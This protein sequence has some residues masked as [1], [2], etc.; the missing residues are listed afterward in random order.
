MLGIT[1]LLS[2]VLSITLF[3]FKNIGRTIPVNYIFCLAFTCLQYKKFII[4]LVCESYMVS[5]VCALYEP[6]TVLMAAFM[7]LGVTLALTVY[8]WLI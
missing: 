6:R 4:L 1:S 3:C 2:I 8:A 7:T 5:C